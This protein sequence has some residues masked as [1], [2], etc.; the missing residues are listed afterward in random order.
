MGPQKKVGFELEFG[1]DVSFL[2]LRNRMKKD[3]GINGVK[4]HEDYS[5]ETDK[6][7]NGELVTPVWNYS[8]GCKNLRRIFKWLRK[9]NITTNDS[10]GLHVNL[11]YKKPLLNHAI[12]PSAVLLLTDDIKWLRKFNRMTN[13]Y[14]ITPKAE[15]S[16]CIKAITRR[17]DTTIEKLKSYM[18]Q[19]VLMEYIE[20]EGWSEEES[21]MDNG[22]FFDKYFSINLMKLV[23]KKPY[24][25]Y[26]LIGGEHYHESCREAD[27]FNCIEHCATALDKSISTRYEGVKS[28]YV[29]NMLTPAQKKRIKN[30]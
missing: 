14:C 5:V 12:D 23:E 3:L 6:K 27:V 19:R 22:H 13:T 30:K 4:I 26:R 18:Y 15:L 7:Y 11:S 28:R 10:T 8:E 16:A 2:T 9:N 1:A 29:R 24:I 20:A 21:D 17:K 25:E